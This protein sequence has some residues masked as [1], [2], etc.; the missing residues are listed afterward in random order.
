MDIMHILLKYLHFM[1]NLWSHIVIPFP[2][3]LN[4][5]LNQQLNC[6]LCP[7]IIRNVEKEVINQPN[8]NIVAITSNSGHF[9]S[10]DGQNSC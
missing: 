8:G 9:V 1:I 10:K 2:G 6:Y 4:F 3:S 7:I 5:T